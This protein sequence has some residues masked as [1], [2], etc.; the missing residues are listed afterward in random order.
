[1]LVWPEEAVEER[2]ALLGSPRPPRRRRKDDSHST[3]PKRHKEDR[4][5]TVPARE[6]PSCPSVEEDE[7]YGVNDSGAA[8]S[9]PS[10]EED[11]EY[12]VNDSGVGD[13]ENELESEFH[14]EITRPES[15]ERVS[16]LTDGVCTK[17]DWYRVPLDRTAHY[18]CVDPSDGVKASV[19]KIWRLRQ[20][21]PDLMEKLVKD[22]SR[23]CAPGEGGYA[24]L[25]GKEVGTSKD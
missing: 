23:H 20:H 6:Q 7:E 19:E 8:A 10:V 21:I 14:V 18:I 5:T 2:Y 9:C 24:D 4:S 15:E 16:D 17:A 3:T 22:H 13:E 1:M 11:E 25:T 12:G